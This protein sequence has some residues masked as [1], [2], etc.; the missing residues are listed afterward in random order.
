MNLVERSYRNSTLALRDFCRAPLDTRNACLRAGVLFLNARKRRENIS[1]NGEKYLCLERPVFDTHAFFYLLVRFKGYNNRL[2]V[3]LASTL[4][5]TAPD[6]VFFRRARRATTRLLS[7][8][9]AT[10]SAFAPRPPSPPL[11]TSFSSAGRR[12][13]R[14][15][16]GQRLRQLR[17]WVRALSLPTDVDEAVHLGAERASPP[18]HRP[19]PRRREEPGRDPSL[20]KNIDQRPLLTPRPPPAPG[21]SAPRAVPSGRRSLSVTRRRSDGVELGAAEEA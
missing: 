5:G 18:P 2:Y 20:L 10:P 3:C 13:R 4:P 8:A 12:R 6:L 9:T 17:L 19:V 21:S 16:H 15:V 1:G 14:L 7:T 11:P